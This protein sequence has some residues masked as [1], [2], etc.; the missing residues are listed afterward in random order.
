MFFNTNEIGYLV[1]NRTIA[2]VLVTF[3]TDEIA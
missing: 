1:K 2:Y 3:N